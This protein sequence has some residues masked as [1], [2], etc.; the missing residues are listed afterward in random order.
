M[1]TTRGRL[2]LSRQGFAEV[3]RVAVSPFAR[4]SRLLQSRL[5]PLV[6]GGTSFLLLMRARAH[7]WLIEIQC[8]HRRRLI[9]CRVKICLGDWTTGRARCGIFKAGNRFLSTRARIIFPEAPLHLALLFIPQRAKCARQRPHA[10]VHFDKI[11]NK[12]SLVS[13]LLITC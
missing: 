11:K 6:I 2:W 7:T 8:V 1:T 9:T 5:S 10:P 3:P 12:P 13:T 4:A